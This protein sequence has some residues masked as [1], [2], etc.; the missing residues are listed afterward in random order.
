MRIP[1]IQ[2]PRQRTASAYTLVEVVVAIL[3][4]GIMVVSLYG[5]FSSGF[6][7]MQLARED[8][9]ATQILMQKMEAVRLCNWRQL[10]NAPVVFSER[11]DPLE[12]STGSAGTVY[13]GVLRVDPATVIP[14]AANYRGNLR[15]VTTKVYWTN[16]S[17]GKR[18]VRSREM[19]TLVARNG[20]QSYLWGA[21]K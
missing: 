13:S 10:S 17:G 7:V 4:V 18:I 3:I 2:S 20:L 14:G 11:Y 16:Y 1:I 6:A 9:R 5:G 8:L 19:Q 15:L 12:I 21:V